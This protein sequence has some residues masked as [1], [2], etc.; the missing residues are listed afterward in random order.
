[1][2]NNNNDYKVFKYYEGLCSSENFPKEIAKVLAL[3]VKSEAIYDADGHISS[4]AGIMKN[5]NWDIVYPAPDSSITYINSDGESETII[6][7]DIGSDAYNKL[8]ED[9]YKCKI[10][11]QVDKISDTVIVR[12]TTTSKALSDEEIDDLTVDSTSNDDTLTMYLEIYK[13]AY[14]ANPEQYPLDCERKGITPK[15]ITKELYQ[16]SYATKVDLEESIYVNTNICSKEINYPTV[17]GQI[18][19]TQSECD[20]Y[21]QRLWTLFD[22]STIIHMP[23]ADTPTSISVAS[24]FITKMAREFGQQNDLY[25]AIKDGFNGGEGIEAKEWAALN[26]I[27]IT[28]SLSNGVYQMLFVGSTEKTVYSIPAGSMYT[29]K[30]TPIDALAPELYLNGSYI[31]LDTSKY[32]QSD[33]IIYFDEDVEFTAEDDG[34]LVV[35]YSYSTSGNGV[36]TDRATLLNNHYVLMRLFDVPNSDFSGP[37]DNVYNSAG[38][39]T[40]T[41]SHISPWS[42]LSWY[43]DFEE[44]FVDDGID[45]DVSTKN[46]SD[47]TLLVP[48]ETPG[49]N[50]DTKMRYWINTN[51]DRF[52]LIVMGNPSLDYETDRH[53]VS[54]CYCGAI[55][56]FDGSIND[57]AGNFALFTS[58]STEPCNTVLST[59]KVYHQMEAITY[60]D[61]TEKNP[62]K[63]AKILE[64]CI[65]SVP[66][67]NGKHQFDLQLT[68]A[69]YF[70]RTQWP[71]YI[72]INNES[73]EAVTPLTPVPQSPTYVMNNGKA[74]SA[75]FTILEEDK[76]Y[77]ENH[78]VYFY[79]GY[80]VEKYTITSGI[81]RDIFGNV[82]GV[83]KVNE[84]GSNTSDGVT[85]IM[86]Y[87]TR[88]KAYYQK[89]HMLFAT[90]EEYMSKVLYGKS[91]YTG[92]YYADRIKVTHGND[93]PRGTL[94]DLLVIDSSSLYALDELVIN[95]DFEKNP[96]EFEE[97]FVYFPITAPF[98]PLSDSPNS[99][100][101]L[102]IKKAQVEPKYEDE[103]KLLEIAKKQLDAL[104]NNYITSSDIPLYSQTKNGCNVYWRVID[105]TQWYGDENTPLTS[106]DP[107]KIIVTKSSEY[108]GDTEHLINCNDGKNDVSIAKSDKIATVDGLTS[109]ITMSGF[110]V[111]DT[112][113]H[114]LCY[115]ISDT[116]IASIGNDATLLVVM[117]D[118][119]EDS[120]EDDIENKWTYPIEGVPYSGQIE[121]DDD[122][123]MVLKDAAPGQ[124]LVVYSVKTG[125]SDGVPTYLIDDYDTA[126]LTNEILQYP[127]VVNVS[128]DSGDGKISLNDG[129][130]ASYINQKVQYKTEVT[131]K[132]NIN[133]PYMFSKAEITYADN[134]TETISSLQNTDE[135]VISSSKVTQDIS[136]S[137]TLNN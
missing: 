85:S 90:T 106:Y 81:S 43:R 33:G 15:L 67:G 129:A 58:S 36:V 123:N 79:F 65:K 73:G 11:N 76:L 103:L 80:Y 118:G 34:V 50:A 130:Y 88:S 119:A 92:E 30:R 32:H 97:T 10:L 64:N 133:E 126:E 44:V 12:T 115:G 122:G 84:Y 89:H 23:S 37:A 112:D 38:E 110:N 62:A 96:D 16:Q 21:I 104:Y 99:T 60:N 70:D 57:T 42:K 55:E 101:G 19:L 48:L 134:S 13:P 49:L 72:I 136:V 24:T 46:L 93:G 87:H 63:I 61:V 53:L 35:R 74:S 18:D 91:S 114:V 17:I 59:E 56:S 6:V 9:E 28:F 40:Q 111:I 8:T 109:Y 125:T 94:S 135:I 116:N 100:Y 41:N 3:G 22:D 95:K 45:S 14:I 117:H 137:V 7:P 5:K 25:G 1:M 77:D 66:C 131:I 108:Q 71:K 68:D 113:N 83:D 26:N 31:P 128:F 75:V 107:V 98:S 78:T 4:P 54:G 47:G 69:T 2:A 27:D 102:A 124:Y 39:I 51:N 120:P 105:G 86:M 82:I 29:V 127:C 132:L 52:S 121:H 20:Y